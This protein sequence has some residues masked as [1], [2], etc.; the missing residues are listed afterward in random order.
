MDD[1]GFHPAGAGLYIADF[2]LHLRLLFAAMVTRHAG[3]GNRRRYD[4]VNRTGRLDN[5][6]S[7][8]L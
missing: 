3:S 7:V 6:R 2:L 4:A 1:E 8:L 5:P